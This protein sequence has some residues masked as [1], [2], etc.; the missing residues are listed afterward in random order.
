MELPEKVGH[1]LFIIL[2]YIKMKD[3]PGLLHN[4]KSSNEKKKEVVMKK[5]IFDRYSRD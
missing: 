3:Y 1:N 5:I 4:T 2:D